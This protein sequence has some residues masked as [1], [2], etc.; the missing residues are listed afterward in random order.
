MLL[1]GGS[2]REYLLDRLNL[3]IRSV[4]V[5]REIGVWHTS[6]YVVLGNWG[7]KVCFKIINKLF[8]VRDFNNLFF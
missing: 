4:G 8:C 5:G 3:S 6:A 7:W 2:I 1:D